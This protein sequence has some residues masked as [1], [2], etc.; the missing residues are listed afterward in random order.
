[1]GALTSNRKRGDECFTL[2]HAH[3][4]L[5]SPHSNS[6]ID[7]HISKKPKFSSMHQSPDRPVSSRSTAFRL[8]RYPEPTPQLR[9]EVHAPCRVLKFGFS[10]SLRR[11]PGLRTS[12][13]S[14][15]KRSAD[16]M[17]NALRNQYDWA[18]RNALST[19]QYF[20]KD[21]E[22][23]EL[24]EPEKDADSEDSSMEELRIDEDGQEGEG[25]SVVSDQKSRENNGIMEA[26]GKMNGKIVERKIQPSSS[27]AVT[28]LT[29][30]NGNLKVDN[31]GKMLDSLSLNHEVDAPSVPLY[32]KLHESAER[33]NAKLRDLEFLIEVNETRRSSL[34]LLHPEKKKGKDIP[35]DAFVPL[36]EEE[37]DEVSRAFSA[38]RRSVLVTHENSNIAITGEIFQCLRPGAWLND[39]VINV[40]LELLKERER[41]EPTKFLKCHFFSTFFYKKLIS[42]RSGYD[43]KSVRR[44]TTQR[45]LGYSLMECDKI[46]VPIHKEIHW[47]LAV[48]NKKDEKF[49]YLDS[50]KGVDTHV[51]KVMARYIVDEVKEKSGEDIDVSAWKHEYV[52]DLPP[53][54]NGSDC[55]MFMI[56]YADFYSRGVGLCFKQENMPYFRM[57]TAKEIL[58][59]RAD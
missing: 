10:T 12:G 50:L 21:K 34:H 59:L 18:K 24:E 48:I 22:V 52:E 20:R 46:F 32:E 19:L 33:R 56:K 43:F 8:Y 57:R 5:Y 17:G 37:E 42:G 54:E 44:W 55:G 45:K 51:L 49:Q 31:A 38:K 41:R 11:E 14:E 47:C 3:P 9:R 25:R 26:M 35:R 23:I 15:T 7:L 58:R 36:T 16:F 27:S 13:V 30:T 40:Y 2:N 53:Q 39:E 1:M 29:N 6:R 28:G 4:S